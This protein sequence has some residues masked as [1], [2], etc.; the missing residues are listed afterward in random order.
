MKPLGQLD[1]MG[2]Y[3]DGVV[4]KSL[5]WTHRNQAGKGDRR[6]SGRV[7][8]PVPLTYSQEGRYRAKRLLV[9]AL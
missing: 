6:A 5:N 7:S 8:A 2:N 9:L 4:G 1:Y 3:G